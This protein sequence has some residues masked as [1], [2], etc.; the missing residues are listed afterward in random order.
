MTPDTPDE[1][2]TLLL[3]EAKRFLEKYQTATR[4]ADRADA[5]LHASLLLGYCALEA[6]INNVAEDFADRPEFTAHEKGL[7]KEKEI[8]FKGGQFRLS[9]SLKMSR[10]EDRLEFLYRRFAGCPLDKNIGWWGHL[11]AGLDLRNALTHSRSPQ[12]ISE[13]DVTDALHGILETIDVLFRAVYHKAYP[14]RSR[15]LDSKLDF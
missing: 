12:V 1:F 14:A 5:Y 2:A 10:L 7:L 8:V 15:Q 6:H 3:E 13:K 4:V 9:P 11:R